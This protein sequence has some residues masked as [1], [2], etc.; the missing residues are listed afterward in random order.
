MQIDTEWVQTDTNWVQID[1][2]HWDQ[3]DTSLGANRH[4]TFLQ[5]LEVLHF[6]S[7]FYISFTVIC[8]WVQIDTEWVQIDTILGT[9]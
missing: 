3:I 6:N 2:T 4:Q 9:N 7:L 8:E 1:T 5:K